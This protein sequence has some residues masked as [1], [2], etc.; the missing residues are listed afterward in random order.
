[1]SYIMSGET[2]RYAPTGI[3][4]AISPSSTA[5]QYTMKPMIKYASNRPA[6]PLHGKICVKSNL[7]L[8][9]WHKL[10]VPALARL[11]PDDK[12]KPT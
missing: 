10:D 5:T 4:A 12:N 6:G 8:G 9:Y 3:Y 2:N 1:M 11:A 7:D